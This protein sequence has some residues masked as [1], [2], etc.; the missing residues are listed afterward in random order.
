MVAK[1]QEVVDRL[2]SSDRST[3]LKAVREIKNQIIGN[4]NKKLSYVRLEAV[5]R[6]VELLQE[7]ADAHLL[8]QSAAT[9]GSFAYGLEDGFRAVVACGGVQ[10]LLQAVSSQDDTV[11]EAALRALKLVWQARNV[12]SHN[13]TMSAFKLLGHQPVI[14]YTPCLQNTA[15]KTT[16]SH[17][18]QSPGTAQPHQLDGL[19]LERIISLLSPSNDKTSQIATQ[20]LAEYCRWAQPVRICCSWHL[21]WWRP[22]QC[23]R[24]NA[25]RY[26]GCCVK[27]C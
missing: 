18:S 11:V 27:A 22:L 8:V 14:R 21:C 16:D 7:S 12:T 13:Q 1:Q 2:R 6:V 17:F 4:K 15:C 3:R 23:T 5:P 25:K 10:H 24:H 20:V 9:V 19:N 26:A